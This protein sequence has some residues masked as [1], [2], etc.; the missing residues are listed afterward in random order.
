MGVW[1]L[2]FS[3][4]PSSPSIIHI[5]FYYFQS[6]EC[7]IIEYVF[8]CVATTEEMKKQYDEDDEEEERNL[9]VICSKMLVHFGVVE[10]NKNL[11]FFVVSYVVFFSCFCATRHAFN[12]FDFCSECICLF[13]ILPCV[14]I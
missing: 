2:Y 11:G 12:S 5:F 7:M 13:Y 1:L 3:T 14:I 8:M 6:L 4:L 10:L 9:K